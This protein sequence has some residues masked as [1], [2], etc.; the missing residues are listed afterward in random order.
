MTFRPILI[1]YMIAFPGYG[2]VLASSLVSL[3]T[4]LTSSQFLRCPRSLSKYLAQRS[5]QLLPCGIPYL[6]RR[7][8]FLSFCGIGI[9]GTSSLS[10]RGND[11]SDKHYVHGAG[12]PIGHLES[13]CQL[14]VKD[15]L[16]FW[17]KT[18]HFYLTI[19]SAEI[20]HMA[21]KL[22]TTATRLRSAM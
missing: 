11:R 1:Y 17:K 3:N 19:A 13:I 15:E 14:F 5:W 4:P 7:W 10:P 20:I 6:T 21:P 9:P 16:F 18:S 12:Y 2:V 8:R 22:P